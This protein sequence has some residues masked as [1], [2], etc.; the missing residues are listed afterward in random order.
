MKKGTLSYKKSGVDYDLLDPVKKL[1]QFEG[2]KTG[3]N[4]KNTA[5][6]EVEDSRGESAYIIEMSDCYLAFVVEGLG[7]KNLI[8]DE[9]SKITGKTYYDTIG[10]DTV[11]SI[12]MDLST[13][14]AKPLS[15]LSY[16]ALGDSKWLKDKKRVTSFILGWKKA[17]NEVG[18]SWGGGET[19]VL[20]DIIYPDRIDLAGAAIGIIKPKNRLILGN[21]LKRGDV[22]ILFESSGIHVNGLTL[23]RK[24]VEK[25]PNGFST[26]L[27]SGNLYG[28]A[29]M[30]PTKSYTIL[31]EDLLS[32]EVEIHYMVNITGHGW[33]KLMRPKK[34]FSYVLEKVPPVSELFKFIQKYS[35]LSD[36]EMY[37]TFNMGAGFAAYVNPK[38]SDKV[39]KISQK[40]NIKAWVAGRVEKGQKKVVIQPLNILFQEKDLQIR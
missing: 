20:K 40:H 31:V 14:G 26:K 7:S 21:K 13:V 23:A 34:P 8:A 30:I 29:L 12:V 35:D 18:I 39:L 19:P 15:V 28:E 10:F 36:K 2:L 9:M 38:D 37:G 24:L 27:P 16:W 32:E 3:N 33:R 1:A 6:S 25:L 4:L 22:I 17:C 11:I 5:F